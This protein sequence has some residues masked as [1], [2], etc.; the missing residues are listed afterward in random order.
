MNPNQTTHN[1]LFPLIQDSFQQPHQTSNPPRQLMNPEVH[2]KARDIS[3]MI[4]S[5]QDIEIDNPKEAHSQMMMMS[6][7]EKE[8]KIMKE[9]DETDYKFLEQHNLEVFK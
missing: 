6:L 2:S 5:N 4:D 1:V 7:Q 8:I 3:Y 9:Q